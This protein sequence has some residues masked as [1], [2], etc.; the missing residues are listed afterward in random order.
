MIVK[1]EA[2]RIE[3]FLLSVVPYIDC[4]VIL[5]TG[6]TDNTI[7]LMVAFFEKHKI[8]FE[9]SFTMFKNF[10]QA[11]NEALE[12][13]RSSKLDWTYLL[14]ADADMEMV[15]TDPSFRDHM[16][17]SSY[18]VP[19]R[20]GGLVYDNRRFL[21]RRN[22]GIYRGV[23]HE[24]LDAGES[25]RLDGVSFVDHADGS[26]RKDKYTRDILLL[27]TALK[28]EPDN[29][30]YWFYLAQSYRDAGC[31]K[32][33]ANAYRKRIALGGWDE[34]VFSAKM[35]LAFALR[36][37]KDEAGFI[38]QCIDAY[39]FRPTRAEPLYDLA[40]HYREKGMNAASV[41]FSE[42]GMP[43][44]QPNDALFV[45]EYVYKT[46]LKQEFSISAFYDQSR[47]ARGFTVCNE[48]ALGLETPDFVRN[49][50]RAN[51]FH[52]LEPLSK[53]CPSFTPHRL[54]DPDPV[55]KSLNPSVTRLGDKIVTTIRTVNYKITPEGRYQIPGGADA[56][57]ITRNILAELDPETLLPTVTYAIDNPLNWPTTPAFPLV[58]GF[59]D[60]RI[61]ECYGGQLWFNACVRELNAEG[62]C[63]QV[64]GHIV[65]YNGAFRVAHWEVMRP[66][67]RTYEK[68][69]MP[70]VDKDAISFYYRLD[71]VV[72]SRGQRP[73]VRPL[74]V[75]ANHMSGGGQIIPFNG[76]TL[77]IVHEA[78]ALPG[79]ATRYYQH[80]FVWLVDDVV[81]WISK[82]FFFHEREIEFAAG[83]A[84]HPDGRRLMISY[85]RRDCEAWIATIDAEELTRWK[86]GDL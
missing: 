14:L 44:Q 80:R 70:F 22:T 56:P 11:R 51:L 43:I 34:E 24:Y 49:E 4:A 52:Y 40:K 27:T 17:E 33:A 65:P 79:R 7:E 10:E 77:A 54:A 35:N 74:N 29:A 47:R 48:L 37:D 66:E 6:S 73:I 71:T 59:E 16:T 61:F 69:W 53:H 1:S 15:V 85:G 3:R 64:L 76:G 46:G 2:A 28:T 68:N 86:L 19:Q 38:A 55:W 20:A 57:I 25:H 84:K 5:D 32:Q 36:D 21:A 63:E 50:A 82:P 9:I 60:M 67:V 81:H 62:Y 30:R 75:A 31:P 12:L 8:K 39:N 26:N 18:D 83:L 13:A 23:T 42:R 45:S 78:N 72:D 41:I 58:I